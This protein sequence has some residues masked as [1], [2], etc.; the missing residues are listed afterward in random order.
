MKS[1]SNGCSY[2]LYDYGGVRN[3]EDLRGEL[4]LIYP[5]KPEPHDGGLLSLHIRRLHLH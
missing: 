4:T 2:F 1:A 3:H 5:P